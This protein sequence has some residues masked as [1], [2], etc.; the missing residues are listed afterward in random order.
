MR[1]YTVCNI[2]GNLVHVLYM[3]YTCTCTC[4]YMYVN[5]HVHYVHVFST[6]SL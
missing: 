4:A 2:V 6:L 1:L 5:A 3:V